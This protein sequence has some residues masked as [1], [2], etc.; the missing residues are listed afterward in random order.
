MPSHWLSPAIV[1]FVVGAILLLAELLVGGFLAIFFGAGAWITALLLWIGLINGPWQSLLVFLLS[2]ILSLVALRRR[3][4]PVVP[5]SIS[6]SQDTDEILDG[7]RGQRAVV[8]ETID[9]RRKTGKVEFRGT[10]WNACS[11]IR[12]DT[13]AVVE[14]VSRD[15]IILRVKSAED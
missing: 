15:N 10:T 7:F 3:L 5:R 12:I 1:W 6:D 14:I 8:V 4:K 13:G 11:D 2:S 9:A